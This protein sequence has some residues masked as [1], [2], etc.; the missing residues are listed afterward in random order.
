MFNKIGGVMYFSSE[1][2]NSL[3]WYSELL[4]VNPNYLDDYDFFYLEI[5]VCIIEFH[6]TDSK[7]SV[8]TEGQV[9]Y[10]N[11]VDFDKVYQRILNHGASIYRAPIKIENGRKMAQLQDP[12]GNII[13][14][15]G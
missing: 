8:G 3:K 6:Q 7:N 10:W 2:K 13:G 14:I 9:C 5:D 12:F 11:V 15:R 4:E 1:P